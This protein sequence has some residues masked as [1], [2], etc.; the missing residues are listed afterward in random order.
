MDSALV[1][2]GMDIGTAKPD[3]ATRAAVPHHLI[4]VADPAE[5]Y[6]AGRFTRDAVAAIEDIA[7]RGR[8]PLLVGGTLL[9]LKAL[10]RGLGGMP[11]ADVVLRRQLDLRADEEGWPALHAELAEAD[12]EAAARIAPTDRQRIQRALEVYMLTGIPI[13]VLQREATAPPPAD[14]AI[15][16]L[17]PPD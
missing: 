14:V 11:Q 1:Y 9:Y 13:S 8:L 2:R 7:S 3:R 6:S 16:A 17:V 12:P 4:D 5:A 15:L 10:T